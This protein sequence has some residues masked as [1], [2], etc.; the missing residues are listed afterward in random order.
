MTFQNIEF[1]YGLGILIPLA[2]LFFLVLKWKKNVRNQM[3]D[4]ALVNNLTAGFSAANY[5]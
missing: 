1:L 4:E 5:N 2:I 3:G